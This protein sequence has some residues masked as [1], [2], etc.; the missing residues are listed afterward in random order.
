[1]STRNIPGGKGGRCV[2]LTTLPPLRDECHEIW[3]PKPPGTL[4]ATPGLLGDSFTYSFQIKHSKSRRIYDIYIYIYIYIVYVNTNGL[5]MKCFP[6]SVQHC[7]CLVG[8][9]LLNPL[10]KC[11]FLEPIPKRSRLQSRTE[12][13]LLQNRESITSL[14][15]SLH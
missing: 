2:R 3:E 10:P 8:K 7:K 12:V 6:V 15:L 5:T 9:E 4:W 11:T 14:G 13:V 1:M